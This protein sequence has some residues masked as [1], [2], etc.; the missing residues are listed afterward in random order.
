MEFGAMG[1]MIFYLLMIGAMGFIIFALMSG[2]KLSEAEQSL[3]TLRLNVNH[4]YSSAPDYSGLSNA[5]VQNA[6]IVPRSINKTNSIR[7]GWNGAIT[8]TSGTDPNTFNIQYA[9]VPREACA[10]LSSSQG[11]SWIS[12]IINGTAIPSGSGQVSAIATA[13]EDTNTIIFVSN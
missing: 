3:T 13:V 1:T 4:F 9:N 12:I 7:N 6:G 10:K 11:S 5:V 8:L 2:S